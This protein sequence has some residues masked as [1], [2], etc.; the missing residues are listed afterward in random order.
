MNPTKTFWMMKLL[1][2]LSQTP[3]TKQ[4]IVSIEKNYNT[5]PEHIINLVDTLY[6]FTLKNRTVKM[7]LRKLKNRLLKINDNSTDSGKNI[8]TSDEDCTPH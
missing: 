1:K 2:I 4:K 7:A 5:N 6:T 8:L 3:T